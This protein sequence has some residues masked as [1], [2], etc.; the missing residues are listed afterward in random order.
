MPPRKRKTEASTL[1]E[2]F[3][4]FEQAMTEPTTSFRLRREPPVNSDETPA[5]IA[6]TVKPMGG[7]VETKWSGI[8]M[9]T[10]PRCRGTTFKEADSKVHVCKTPRGV[11]QADE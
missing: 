4:D 6:Q 7:M 8:P 3:D 5:P 11:D 10:C 1:P 2:K 9:W